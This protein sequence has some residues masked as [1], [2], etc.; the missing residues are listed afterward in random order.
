MGG[1]G[2]GSSGGAGGVADS[3]TGLWVRIERPIPSMHAPHTIPTRLRKA[4][5][6]PDRGARIVSAPRIIRIP[7]RDMK[8]VYRR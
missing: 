5:G 3:T 1:G 6:N 2:G 7:E 8:I 4:I